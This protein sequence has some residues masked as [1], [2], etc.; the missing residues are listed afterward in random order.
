MLLLGHLA[1]TA[2]GIG[3]LRQSYPSSGSFWGMR[4]SLLQCSL[5]FSLLI[6]VGSLATVIYVR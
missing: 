2:R 3:H 6:P 5:V 4:W 1:G